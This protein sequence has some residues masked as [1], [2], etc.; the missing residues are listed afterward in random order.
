MTT[1][2]KPLRGV[3][4]LITIDRRTSKPV[5][6]QIYEEFRNRVLRNQV[7]SGQA[8]PST[9]QLA[10]DLRI[11]R[12]PVL[13]AYAQLIAEGYFETRIGSGTFISASLQPASSSQPPLH[14]TKPAKSRCIAA[15]SESLP[16]YD[17]PLWS[18]SLGPFQVGQP[19][20]HSFP[21]VVWSRLLGR[22]ARSMRVKGL[23]Y[24]DSFGM[25]ELRQAIAAY[26]RTS[27]AVRCTAEQVMI[28]SGSQQALDLSARV[29]LD[30]NVPVWLEEPGYWLMQHVLKAAGCAI[31]PVPVDADGLNVALGKKLAP[32]ARAAFV[33]PSHQYPLGV[34]M[35]A[36]RRL[37]LLKWAEVAGAWIIEDDYDSEYRYDSAPVAS[38]QGLDR[39]DRVIYIGNF[40]KVMFPSLRLGYL[41]VPT[42]LIERF[43]AVR[44][45][46][47]I[48]PPHMN[49]AVMNEFIREGHFSRHLR[50]MRPVYADRRRVLIEALSREL[51]NRCSIVGD[52]AGMHL[53]IYVDGCDD[54][55]V[56]RKAAQQGIWLSPLSSSYVGEGRPGLI[57]GFGNSKAA[58]IASCVPRL[59][60]LLDEAGSPAHRGAPYR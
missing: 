55:T 26:L 46:M 42:D 11:S 9:R 4:N 1:S 50:R 32:K 10:R 34:T 18:E 14:S 6:Q 29:L 57:L 45:T 52:Q 16:P 56:A 19:D 31:V 33:S 53:T 8:V 28:V 12:L 49:Q 37:Q 35:T 38:L 39:N 5:R 17:R 58:Q 3:A 20:L 13:D 54:K 27:R 25:S 40:S 44:Q 51:G 15:R 41:V 47:D 7:H 21:M 24:G 22:Y 43:A 23:Q 48:C 2:G 36:A 30:V 59:R 60:K